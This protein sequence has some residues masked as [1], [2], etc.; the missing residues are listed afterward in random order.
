MRIGELARRAGANIQTIRFYER[1]RLLREPARTASGYRN[2]ERGDLDSLAFIK[3][4]QP[5]G[6]TL[7]EVR[8]LLQLHAA[9]ARLPAGN[10]GT[11]PKE[12]KSI[13]RMGE[14][15]LASIEEKVRLLA[16]MKKQLRSVIQ[17]LR[18]R[19]GLICPAS[20]KPGVRNSS[21]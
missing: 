14:E 11:K 7:K 1:Q 13:V 12:L 10:R 18:G 5:L 6:F 3:W 16:G 2:Y 8:Q 21:K 17:E 9:V 15:K 20:S 19:Q 4:C